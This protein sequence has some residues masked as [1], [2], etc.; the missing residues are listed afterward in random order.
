MQWGTSLP[1]SGEGDA[2]RDEEEPGK[3]EPVRRVVIRPTV[4]VDMKQGA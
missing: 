3:S 1:R 4:T 2:E